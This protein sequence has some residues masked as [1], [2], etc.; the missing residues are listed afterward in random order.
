MLLTI[1]DRCT[2]P[3]VRS[4]KLLGSW[5]NFSKP[6]VMERD[7]RVGAG[8]WRGCHTFSNIVCDG[9]PNS[10]GRARSGGLKMG[11]TYWYYVRIPQIPH[12]THSL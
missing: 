8:H 9:Q 11:G 2:A 4:V 1:L 6:Y 5:D 10:M 12:C 7:K 3:H